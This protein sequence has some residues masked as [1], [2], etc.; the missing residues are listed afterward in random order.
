LLESGSKK[1]PSVRKLLVIPTLAL[2]CGSAFADSRADEE[3]L[4]Q[5]KAQD[6]LDTL[7]LRDL[8]GIEISSVSRKLETLSAAPASIFLITPEDIRRT[9]AT[10][11]PEALRIVPGLHVARIDANK[12]A[13]SSRGFASQY[14][15]KLLVMVDGRTV[16]TPLFSGVY[17]DAQDLIMEDVE[18]I[19]VIRG[20]GAALWGANAVNGVINV[21][22]RSAKD[23]DGLLLSGAGGSEEGYAAVRYGGT[24]GEHFAYRLYGKYSSQNG[25]LDASGDTAFDAW[26]IASGG[27]R[28]DWTKERDS[29]DIVANLYQGNLES[30]V[31]TWSMLP[32]FTT[33]FPSE[34]ATSGGNALARWTRNLSL[35]ESLSFQA[36]YDR[37]ERNEPSLLVETRNTIDLDFQHGLVFGRND[38]VWGAHYRFTSDDLPA[39]GSLHWNETER[40]DQLFSVFGQ[41]RISLAGDRFRV[42]LGAKLEHNDYTGFEFQPNVRLA[43]TAGEQ[44]VWGAVARAV[45]T[46]SRFEHTVNFDLAVVP[47]PAGILGVVTM[48]GND[49]FLSEEV[50]DYEIGYRVQPAERFTF[51]V[52]G[53][54]ND[55]DQLS[56][57]EPGG[58]PL[59]V[60]D[61]TFPHLRIPQTFGNLTS[62]SGRGVEVTA[63]LLPFD[64][65]RLSA[66]YSRLD[67]DLIAGELSRD[68]SAESPEGSS[69]QNQLRLQSYLDLPARFQ[70]DTTVHYVDELPAQGTPGYTRV[71]LRFGWQATDRL[72]LAV[73]G[74]NLLDDQHLEFNAESFPAVA[75]FVERS[76]FLQIRW[77]H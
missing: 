73:V 71:D 61:P 33:T 25:Y 42:T 45:R 11:V 9:G 49:Q 68:P 14:S 56:S 63:N 57:V 43:W 47:T 30:T 36:Y 67:L 35:G 6:E 8:L 28:L 7:S 17:W 65:W 54:F 48:N 32:P 75:S 19:E 44:T 20:P 50:T 38:L 22:T 16:Y 69:P 3:A 55:Y 62:G 39:T 76:V 24:K 27:V 34:N 53:F 18:R 12:W 23:T 1:E 4:P 40:S 77:R 70:L 46:P 58:F 5:P 72:E 59:F 31:R 66:S 15:N 60:P 74:Q 10:S 26:D 29:W 41:D 13:I 64:P 21:I 51:D 37:Y 2:V 52:V